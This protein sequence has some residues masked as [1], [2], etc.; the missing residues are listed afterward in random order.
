[1]RDCET[2]GAVTVGVVV[3]TVGIAVVIGFAGVRST[4]VSVKSRTI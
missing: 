4:V 2:G 3:V 1:M